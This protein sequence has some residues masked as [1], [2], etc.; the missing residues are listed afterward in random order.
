MTIYDESTTQARSE[1]MAATGHRTLAE[2]Y[3]TP[4]NLYEYG[5]H[6]QEYL[7]E[8]LDRLG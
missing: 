2:R 4:H 1:A 5:V 8:Q 3:S 6:H 7:G